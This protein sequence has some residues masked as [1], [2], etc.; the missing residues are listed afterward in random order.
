MTRIAI[1]AACLLLTAAM[2][3]ADSVGFT[4]VS[5]NSGAAALL[6]PQLN[7]DTASGGPLIV[8]FTVTN[9]GP[10]SSVI[11]NVYWDDN[12]GVLDGFESL[13]S[14]WGTPGAPGDLPSAPVGFVDDYNADADNPK[15]VEGVDVAEDVVF[16]FYL[17][18]GKTA[19]DVHTALH[20]G[21]LVI[22][23]HVISYGP[24]SESFVTYGGPQV[25]EPPA[26]VLLLVVAWFARRRLTATATA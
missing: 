24:Y 15:P 5:N 14:N 9:E 7:V 10:L 2:A 19:D 21:S 17:K 23:L 3:H 16:G 11:A 4:A 25:P 18:P 1:T 8:D 6:V 13:P 12:A 20:D 26:L 22:G